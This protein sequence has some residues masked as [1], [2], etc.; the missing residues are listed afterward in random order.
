MVKRFEGSLLRGWRRGGTTVPMARIRVF[1]FGRRLFYY[2]Y[3]K[4]K[5]F[6]VFNSSI[7][8]LKGGWKYTIPRAAEWILKN[9]TCLINAEE[10]TSNWKNRNEIT[11]QTFKNVR[12]E[13]NA[14][15]PKFVK[16][17]R[18]R[19]NN[20]FYTMKIH[21]GLNMVRYLKKLSK[22]IAKTAVFEN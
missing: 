2:R 4:N 10:L 3:N 20:W 8:F 12:T 22:S 19:P 15:I 7:N 14:E 18:L 16:M 9:N 21:F 17:G 13:K 1:S 5:T 11:E 6:F